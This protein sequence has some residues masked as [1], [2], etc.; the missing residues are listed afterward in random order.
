MKLRFK[1]LYIVLAAGWLAAA[2]SSNLLVLNLV[3][4]AFVWHYCAMLDR[5]KQA[6]VNETQLERII[7]ELLPKKVPN[8]P[9]LL[10][11]VCDEQLAIMRKDCTPECKHD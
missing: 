4:G 8:L 9:G 11:E 1:I 6:E 2:Y 10:R 7:F 3:A 5:L